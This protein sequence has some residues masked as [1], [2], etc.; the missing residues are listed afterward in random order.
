MASGTS[1]QVR[2]R[3]ARAPPCKASLV[4]SEGN[5]P[6]APL[7]KDTVTLAVVQSRAAM[8]SPGD[9]PQP[10]I[11]QNLQHVSSLLRSACEEQSASPDII[12]L[13]EFPLTGYLPGD[14]SVKQRA[15]VEIP[16]PESAALGELSREFDAYM[17]FGAYAKDRDF[18]QHILN[19]T[20]ILGRDGAVAKT[21]WKPRNIKRF[22]PGIEIPGTTVE[23]VY[24]R[25]VDKYGLDDVFP[26]LQTEFGNL[27]ATNVQLDPLV[28]AAFGMKGAEIL[29]RTSTLFSP[30]DVLS[31][32]MA[33]QVYSAMSNMAVDQEAGGMSMVV[34][35]AGKVLGQLAQGDEE[36]VLFAD[37]PIAK[38]REGRRLPQH[39]VE[40][41]GHVFADYVEEIPL[42]H[43]DLEPG[44]L[45]KDE[46]EMKAHLDRES[47]WLNGNGSRLETGQVSAIVDE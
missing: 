41:T 4:D 40:L 28:M 2:L 22:F 27:A 9:D 7:E 45:P 14:R 46:K 19:L 6:R 20:T 13:H 47:R 10:V 44:S 23:G 25:F 12:V 1:S 5:Y 18:P 3:I 32:A 26:V 24:D 38:F 35:P 31:T 39:S 43:M 29:L 33:N 42:N 16:G 11:S 8:I 17:V 15:C 37:V 34:D 36:G 21:V 30:S